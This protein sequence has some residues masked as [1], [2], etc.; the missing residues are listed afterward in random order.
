MQG[1]S[2]GTLAVLPR[3]EPEDLD[4]SMN[5]ERMSQNRGLLVFLL[6]LRCGG[7]SGCGKSP[8]GVRGGSGEGVAVA[9]PVSGDEVSGV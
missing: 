8:V 2:L 5:F 9:L 7:V 3:D 6:A 1:T 4:E